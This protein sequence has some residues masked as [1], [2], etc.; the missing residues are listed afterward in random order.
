[1][2]TIKLTLSYDGTDFAGWQIQPDQPTVQATLEATIEKITGQHASV[3]GSGRTDAG[4]HALGQVASFRTQSTLPVHVLQRALN[5]QLP[6]TIAVLDIAEA[7][8]EFH[9]I[10]HALRKQYRYVIHDGPN[11]D[12][13]RRHYCWQ[14]AYG[15]LDTEAMARAAAALVGTHDFSSFETS[16]APRKTSVRTVFEIS[17]R[18]GRGDQQD[19]ITLEIEADGFLYNMV[20]AIVGTL[21]EV[22]RGDRP[23]IWPAEVLR[24]ADR[25]L[26]GQTAPPQGLFLV[27]VDYP[28]P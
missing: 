8:P 24:A 4:V 9:P 17:I 18:R 25:R 23:E 2:R 19:F 11:R 7:P 14:Y 16:G 6:R 13:F 10:V 1:M 27:K 20:R 21:I 28:N 26:A 12:V 22:G 5:A 15:R 3:L